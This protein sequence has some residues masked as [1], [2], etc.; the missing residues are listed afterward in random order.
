MTDPKIAR[1]VHRPYFFELFTIANLLII[2]GVLLRYGIAGALYSM[3]KMMLQ[4]IPP[5]IVQLIAGVIIRAVVAHFRGNGELR[6]YLKIVRSKAWLLDSAR[7]L[8]FITL[9]IHTYAWI[10]L[11][12]PVMHPR[13]FD[14]QLWDLD[15]AISFGLSPTVFF[16]SIFSNAAALRF[17]DF[18]YAYV[19]VASINIAFIYFLSSPSRRVRIAFNDGNTLM[20]IAS[21]WLYVL[22]P[23]LGPAYRFPQV[24]L[25]YAPLLVHTQYLQSMLMTNYQLVIHHA[26]TP[27][28][29]IGI[30]LGVAAFPS[31]HVAF[32][33][34]VFLWM[35]R[36]WRY[37]G[38]VFGIFTLFIFI[39][40]V[41]TGWHYLIDSIAGLVLA[42]VSYAIFARLY[43]L[44]RWLKLGE[45]VHG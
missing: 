38:I 30:L 9:T 42:Y 43:R 4:L 8:F 39:G 32:Q 29:P 41:V 18:T 7:L 23:S 14:Q 19:F 2:H 33:M 21:A 45:I 10:K 35:R 37:G 12:I 6:A 15:R 11:T 16:L 5:A 28:R 22:V 25:E 26:I 20:W 40:S 3:P 34:Y 44:N 1:A 27:D 17:V 24:W 36:L 31:M 13:L